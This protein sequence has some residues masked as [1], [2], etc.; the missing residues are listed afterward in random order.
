[1][2][3]P[4]TQE[5]AEILA[6]TSSPDTN[7]AIL[8]EKITE[9]Q[10][11]RDNAEEKARSAEKI[12]EGWKKENVEAINALKNQHERFMQ[13]IAAQLNCKGYDAT[14]I[15][16]SIEVLLKVEDSLRSAHNDL[17]KSKE[18]HRTEVAS[19]Q[20]EIAHL[21][22]ELVQQANIN[23][24]LQLRVD[25]LEARV[26]GVKNNQ[27]TINRFQALYNSL[28]RKWNDWATRKT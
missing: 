18:A 16:Q 27:V 6:P 11:E 23:Q 13:E 14:T 1:M 21:R 2:I 7:I 10:I 24:T 9:L 5:K 17:S 15:K 22:E 28:V 8:N 26:C 20:E 3:A 4:L 12:L 19:L 25:A